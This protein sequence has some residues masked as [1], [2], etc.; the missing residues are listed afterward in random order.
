MKET[1]QSMTIEKL[2]NYKGLVAEMRSLK[3]SIDSLYNTYRSPQLMSDGGSHSMNTGSPTENAVNKILK[4]KKIYNNKRS[5][6]TDLLLEVEAWL[7]TVDDPEIRSIARFHYVLGYSWQRTN[8][9]V[10]GYLSYYAARKRL[11]RYLGKEA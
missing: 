1:T 11:M 9:A 8:A 7:S 6:A 4:L 2:E 3:E 5:E 10:Y